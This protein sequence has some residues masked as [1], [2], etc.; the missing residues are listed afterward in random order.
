MLLLFWKCWPTEKDHSAFE[1]LKYALKHKHL[2]FGRDGQYT[3]LD[4]PE[5]MYLNRAAKLTLEA[6][7]GAQLTLE[8]VETT[9][10]WNSYKI[11]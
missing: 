6:V 10:F 7:G 8:A 1:G 11:Y 4:W 9:L 2:Q 3:F 5:I